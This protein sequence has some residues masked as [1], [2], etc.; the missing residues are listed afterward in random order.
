[1]EKRAAFLLLLAVTALLCVCAHDYFNHPTDYGY[2]Y[3]VLNLT[4]EDSEHV[5]ELQVHLQ[6]MIDIR[7]ASSRTYELIR[8]LLRGAYDKSGEQV[9]HL[10]AGVNGYDLFVRGLGVGP[11]VNLIRYNPGA[12]LH[13]RYEVDFH[14]M[15]GDEWLKASQSFASRRA[16][17]PAQPSKTETH[18]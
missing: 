6:P 14:F 15:S 18:S 13:G 1:M 3:M 2:R 17:L 7:P 11:Q 16:S 12:P 10:Q 4:L 8:T 5:G 9:Q